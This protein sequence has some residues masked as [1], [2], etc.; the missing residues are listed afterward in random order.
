LRMSHQKEII[1]EYVAA[2]KPSEQDDPPVLSVTPAFD[3]VVLNEFGEPDIPEGTLEWSQP[4]LVDLGFDDMPDRDLDGL[5]FVAASRELGRQLTRRPLSPPVRLSNCFTAVHLTCNRQRTVEGR[6]TYPVRRVRTTHFTTA[7]FRVELL[8]SPPTPKSGLSTTRHIVECPVCRNTL[9]FDIV[10][11]G[12]DDNRRKRTL[13]SLFRKRDLSKPGCFMVRGQEDEPYYGISHTVWDRDATCS[14]SV[15]ALELDA[16]RWG[17]AWRGGSGPAANVETLHSWMSGP[18]SAVR[19]VSS[20]ANTLGRNGPCPCG[21]GK[22][23]KR[24]CGSSQ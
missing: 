2:A 21:S 1:A 14:H 8:G 10:P 22:K 11:A 6:G 19:A 9:A 16:D 12:Q 4:H 20:T 15:T 24:C 3:C 17:L 7:P 18:P 13:R 23:Y 5:G